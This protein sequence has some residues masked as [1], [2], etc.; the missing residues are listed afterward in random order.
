[1]EHKIVFSKKN[2]LVTLLC[3]FFAVGCVAP[4]TGLPTSTSEPIDLSLGA[5]IHTATIAPEKTDPIRPEQ[6]SSPTPLKQSNTQTITVTSIPTQIMLP[7]LTALFEPTMTAAEAKTL[8]FNMLNDNGDC[9]LP[10]FWGL[11]PQLTDAHYS[12]SFMQRFGNTV[13]DKDIYTHSN[14]ID[15]LEGYAEVNLY[16]DRLRTHVSIS[17]YNQKG[18]LEQIIASA[19]S[20]IE[21]GSGE[22]V[23]SKITFGESFFTQQL[24]YYTLPNVL[25][26]YDKPSDVLILPILYGAPYLVQDLIS[27]VLLYQENGFMVEYIFPLIYD[28][29][30]LVGCPNQVGY[31]NIVTWPKDEDLSM[32]SILSKKSSI[33][34]NT[35]NINSYKSIED[36]TSS[37]INEF[38]KTFNNRQNA[39]CIKTPNSLWGN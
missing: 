14:A 22:S 15:S 31:I 9:S 3:I 29:E 27:L 18:K 37:T 12:Q 39:S 35:L 38:Y 34:M 16:N 25:N 10:C 5:K 6:I 17:Y 20:Y 28:D 1:M 4:D 36:A 19:E 21:E 13:S 33:G 8:V 24:D 26:N 23:N 11:S 30:L 7:T 2:C 32:T